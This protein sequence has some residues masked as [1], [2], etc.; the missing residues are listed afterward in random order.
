MS[1]EG[2]KRLKDLAQN[3]RARD[4]IT[5][6]GRHKKGLLMIELMARDLTGEDG[7][8]GLKLWRDAPSRFRLQRGTRNADITLEWQ[9]EIGAAVMTC[10]KHGE[11]KK[12]SRYIVDEATDAWRRMEGEGGE[13][14]ADMEEALVEY[15]YPEAKQPLPK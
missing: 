12:L 8:P 5:D 14:Y 13:L 3:L 15:L 7:M 4:K 1:E 11:A 2:R 6:E 9:R 10:Q